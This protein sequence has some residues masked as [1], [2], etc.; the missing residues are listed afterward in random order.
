MC[1]PLS[2]VMNLHLTL[3]HILINTIAKALIILPVRIVLPMPS[4]SSYRIISDSRIKKKK[5][6]VKV[7]LRLRECASC[8]ALTVH[9]WP[10]STFLVFENNNKRSS[11]VFTLGYITKTC[12][13]KY[14]DFF[15]HQ[16]N[17]N[18]Q[19]KNSD[20]F[21]VSA[22]NIDCGYSLEPPRRVG[23]R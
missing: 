4:F 17:E 12:L 20:I 11:T 21:H 22:Q 3:I 10:Q 23:T 19:I 2:G 15:Y 5:R 9:I 6:A 14:T 13:F 8:S 18:I 7:V 16:K 1:V